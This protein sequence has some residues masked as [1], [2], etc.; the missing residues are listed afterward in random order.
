MKKNTDAKKHLRDR[1]NYSRLVLIA[2]I[3]FVSVVLIRQQSDINYYNK[4]INDLNTQISKEE[5]EKEKLDAKKEEYSSDDYIEKVAR[6]ELGLVMA[7]EKV[8]V[9]VNNK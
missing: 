5:E 7:D 2:V 1:I 8:F 9:D 4:Q 3:I 6:D